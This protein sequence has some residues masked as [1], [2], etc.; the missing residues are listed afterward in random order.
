MVEFRQKIF[1]SKYD[2]TDNLKRMKDADILAEEEKEDPGYADVATKTA[3]AAGSGALV[4]GGLGG[5]L[6][7]FRKKGL[8]K[9]IK[10]GALVGSS[11]AAIYAATKALKKRDEEVQNNEFYNRRLKY[12]QAQARR[13][14]MKDW[15]TNMTQRDGYS[16]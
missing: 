4:G 13:R 10:R 12:A 14:E 6:G 11:A 9:G 5:A 15:K 16:F 3:L 1:Y 8:L 7:L 2:T